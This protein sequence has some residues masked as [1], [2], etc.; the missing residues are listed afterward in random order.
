MPCGSHE[1]LPQQPTNQPEP[2]QIVTRAGEE[3]LPVGLIFLLFPMAKKNN[4]Y[5]AI[6]LTIIIIPSQTIY[7]STLCHGNPRHIS[8]PVENS[9]TTPGDD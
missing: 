3:I 5:E 6:S 7:G 8:T 9:S 1:N 4:D 2:S